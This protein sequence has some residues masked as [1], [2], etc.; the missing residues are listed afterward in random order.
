MH[1]QLVRELLDI[2]QRHRA[3]ARRSGLFE[4]LERALRKGFYDNE[5]DA[6]ARAHARRAALERPEID[7]S[8]PDPLDVADG[9]VR[10]LPLDVEVPAS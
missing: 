1:F 3:Q 8:D 7:E 6:T 4:S 2:E 5:D 10:M 9:F